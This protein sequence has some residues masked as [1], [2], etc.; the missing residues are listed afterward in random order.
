MQSYLP[1]SQ[2]SVKKK[3]SKEK[4][5]KTKDKKSKPHENL[6]RKFCS[7]LYEFI[8]NEIVVIKFKLHNFELKK[9]GHIY[10]I[11]QINHFLSFNSTSCVNLH[12]IRKKHIIVIIIIICFKSNK[13][14]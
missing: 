8:N 3:K 9:F 1:D 2:S 10:V 6:T 12:F 11:S 13:F 14:I 5:S 7:I 4:K